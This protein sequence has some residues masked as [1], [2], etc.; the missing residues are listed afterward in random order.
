[1]RDAGIFIALA[2]IPHADLVEI[3]Q[4]NRPCDGVDQMGVG[5]RQW[6]DIGQVDFQKVGVP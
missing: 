5:H 2:E 6:D 3:V 4:T 1:M